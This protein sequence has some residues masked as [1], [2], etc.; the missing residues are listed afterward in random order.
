MAADFSC[1]GNTH[2]AKLL[3]GKRP[4]DGANADGHVHEEPVDARRRFANFTVWL[5]TVQSRRPARA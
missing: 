1:A 3:G 5:R 4:D 2:D